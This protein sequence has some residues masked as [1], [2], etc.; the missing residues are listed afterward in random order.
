VKPI[1]VMLVEDH[2]LVRAGISGLLSSLPDIEVV[3]EAGSGPQAL[4]LIAQHQPD[5]VMM[6]ID[7]PGQNGLETTKQ[8]KQQYSGVRVIILSMHDAQ[9]YV[10]QALRVGAAGY[11]LKD[12]PLAELELAIRA[13][14][15]G[16]IYLTPAVSRHVIQGNGKQSDA[17]PDD[18]LQSDGLDHALT[19]RQAEIVQLVAKGKTTQQIAHLLELSPKTVEAHRAQVMARLGIYDVAGLVRYAIKAGLCSLDD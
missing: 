18:R 2:A 1:R 14:A 17:R 16:D 15:R 6:D 12:A 19:H 4:P 13:V 7:L 8:I 5:V 10:R 9:A 3:A 11:L